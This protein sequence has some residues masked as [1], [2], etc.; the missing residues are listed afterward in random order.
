MV[1]M[2]KLK[3]LFFKCDRTDYEAPTR[4]RS[5]D[6]REEKL[7]KFLKLIAFG[8]QDKAEAMLK[9]DKWLAEYAGDVTDCAGRAFEQITGFQYA[10]WALD[11]QMW[12]M[13]K[14]YISEEQL[15]KQLKK[16]DLEVTL[17]EQQGWVLRTEH[18]IDWLSC[19]WYPLI[20]ALEEYIKNYTIWNV[21]QRDNHWCQQVGGAQLILPAHVINEYRHPTRPFYPCPKWGNE[22]V[23]LPRTGIAEWC[24]PVSDQKLGGHFAWEG[25]VGWVHVTEHSDMSKVYFRQWKD[26]HAVSELLK[27]RTEQARQL[28]DSVGLVATSGN[29]PTSNTQI[30]KPRP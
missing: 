19:S 15:Y 26:L 14:Q 27:S 10:V 7:S 9:K 20:K 29:I 4:Q 8:E 2:K 22:E 12:R 6:E 21:T 5:I 23:T 24:E 3:E 13:I 1:T 18:F 11:F 28:L 25:G 30:P 17:D 16:L